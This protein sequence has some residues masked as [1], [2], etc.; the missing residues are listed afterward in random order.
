[1]TSKIRVVVE[2]SE[3]DLDLVLD[4]RFMEIE[5]ELSVIVN[6][7]ESI[8]RQLA[9]VIEDERE[10]LEG[11]LTRADQDEYY[12]MLHW[13]DEFADEV[14]PRLYRSPVLVQLWAVFESAIIEIARYIR[15][16]DQHAL[17]V[18]DLRGT[19]DF[20]RSQKYYEHVLRF[21]LIEIEG[22]KEQLN[23]LLLVRNGIAHCNGRV[24]AIKPTKIELIRRWEESDGG[25]SV[26]IYYLNLSVD[27]VG[28]MAQ[29]VKRSLEDLIRRVKEKY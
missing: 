10:K 14:L 22:I 6:H 23:M 13:I 17:T 18:D 20:E 25:I 27:F 4:F 29:A 24:E 2:A 5:A 28:E 11:E 3:P 8:E 19:N 15:E 16:Q 21:P 1:V 7:A 12:G 9:M 26:G